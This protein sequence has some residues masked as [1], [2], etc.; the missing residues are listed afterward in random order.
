MRFVIVA[1]LALL[2]VFPA[3]A[4]TASPGANFGRVTCRQTVPCSDDLNNALS[5][6]ALAS[7]ANAC[8]T[9]YFGYSSPSGL[10]DEMRPVSMA[11]VV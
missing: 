10:F 1:V 7:I 9:Q 3:C 2:F 5:P 11:M 4:Q 6:S 8:I